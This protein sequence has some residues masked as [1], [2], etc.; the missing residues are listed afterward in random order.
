MT[1]VSALFAVSSGRK[2]KLLPAGLPFIIPLSTA[3]AT[4]FLAQESIV[5]WSRKTESLVSTPLSALCM[6]IS[7]KAL[8]LQPFSFL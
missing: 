5:L 1:A 6:P 4:S 8:L 2:L 7:L 3:K